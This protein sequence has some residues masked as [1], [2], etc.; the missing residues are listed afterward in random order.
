MPTRASRPR[1]LPRAGQ[2]ELLVPELDPGPGVGLVVVRLGQGHRHVRVMGPGG[3]CGA[4]KRHHEP[5]VGCVHENVTGIVREQFR[6]LAF[7]P[8][9]ELHR[10]AGRASAARSALARS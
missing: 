9:V 2:R 3:Q 8:G 5:G 7:I 6:D 4:V 10:H 1:S